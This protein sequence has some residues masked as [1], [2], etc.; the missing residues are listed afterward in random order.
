MQPHTT[1]K[2]NKLQPMDI[3]S[4]AVTDLFPQVR[5][6][7]VHFEYLHELLNH[8]VVKI[9][10]LNKQVNQLEKRL[11]SS[12]AA[13][14]AQRRAATFDTFTVSHP[15]LKDSDAGLSNSSRTL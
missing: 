15:P 6:F 14:K 4:T 7:Q 1:R 10:S 5:Y 2:K 12:H 9:D 8:A 13:D 11:A 3:N